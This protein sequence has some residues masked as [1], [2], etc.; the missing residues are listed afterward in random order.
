MQILANLMQIYPALAR[1]GRVYADISIC[2]HLCE[3]GEYVR[4]P[5]KR[6]PAKGGKRVNS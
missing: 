6:D 3:I 4:F 2:D 1:K 5:A